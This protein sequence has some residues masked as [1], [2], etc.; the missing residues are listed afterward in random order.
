[1]SHIISGAGAGGRVHSGQSDKSGTAS[2][3]QQTKKAA[4]H[5]ATKMAT[6]KHVDAKE[7]EQHSTKNKTDRLESLLLQSATTKTME[8]S[9][10]KRAFL[11]EYDMIDQQQN[12]LEH[13]AP[14]QEFG[15]EGDSAAPEAAM[16]EMIVEAVKLR[17]DRTEGGESVRMDLGAYFPG[18]SFNLEKEGAGFALSFTSKSERAIGILQQ[19]Q[20]SLVQALQSEVGQHLTYKVTIQQA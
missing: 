6:F 11:N 10:I 19:T 7:Q 4:E 5:F 12:G 18:T 13:T 3:A 16:F 17:V 20:S 9:F 1:M 14:I 2:D 8:E 15:V